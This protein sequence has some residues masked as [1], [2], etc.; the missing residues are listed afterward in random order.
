MKLKEF[1]ELMNLSLEE[2]EGL[3]KKKDN[4]TIDLNKEELKKEKDDLMIKI[5]NAI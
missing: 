5:E 3:L 1:A 2:A 4:I